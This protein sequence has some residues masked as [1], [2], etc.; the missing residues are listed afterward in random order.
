MSRKVDVV[1]IG[2]GTAGLSALAQVRRSGKSFV[3]I[4]GGEE[5]TTCARVGCMPS[6]ALIEAANVFHSRMRFSALGLRGADNVTVDG[7]AVLARVR[8]VRDKLV[9]GVIGGYRKRLNDQEFIRGYARLLGP[10]C[11]EVNG[12]RIDTDVIIIA[13]G[14]SPVLPEAFSALGDALIT[15]DTLFEQ[16]ALPRSLAVVGLGAVGCEA[17]QALARLGVKV[18][19]FDAAPAIAGIRDPEI[20]ALAKSLIA[21]DMRVI[22][23]VNVTPGQDDGRV[24]IEAGGKV[25]TV[26]RVLASLGRR[27][28]V[29]DLG[30]D[31]LGVPLND[32]GM[33]AFDRHTLQVGDLPVFIAGDVNADRAV[34]HEAADEGRIA[35]IN[36]TASDT[37][38]FIRRVPLTIAFT[39][40]QIVSV[41]QGWDELDEPSTVVGTYQPTHHGRAMI[42]GQTEGMLRIYAERSSGRLLGAS[43][44][45]ADAE[46]LGHWLALAIDRG[47]TLA[48]CLAQSFYHPVME[49]ALREALQACLSA[50]DVTL[51]HP[52]GFRVQEDR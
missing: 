8:D 16:T 4:N 2:A 10:D 38:S 31:T 22:T 39:S 46:H 24:R 6:K 11:V 35:A 32:K 48:D 12:E 47:M 33:P 29:S 17:G 20:L 36:A 50:C 18:Y 40:P 43:L 42:K 37:Q 28:N 26:D 21:R 13:A 15:T 3:L 7:S 52:P 45:A 51:D 49:E 23:D 1:I 25:Y 9:N 27:P 5:G 14:S 44:I 41:G 19:G 30:L 34:L